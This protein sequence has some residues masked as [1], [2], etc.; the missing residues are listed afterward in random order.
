MGD[1]LQRV[2]IFQRQHRHELLRVAGD[3]ARCEVLANPSVV[4]ARLART[5][6]SVMASLP[7]P[8]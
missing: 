3:D 8:I 4:L 6:L 2:E 1:F 7:T 5:L